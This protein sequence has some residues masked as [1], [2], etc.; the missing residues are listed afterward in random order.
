MPVTLAPSLFLLLIIAAACRDNKPHS[1][2][3]VPS[4]VHSSPQSTASRT[5]SAS[6]PFAQL[7]VAPPPYVRIWQRP[8]RINVPEWLLAHQISARFP[9][10]ECWET[11]AGVPVL[12]GLFCVRYTVGK[13]LYSE[14]T[15]VRAYRS[16]GGRLELVW[17]G[18][19]ALANNSLELMPSISADGKTLE[20]ADAEPDRCFRVIMQACEKG[21]DEKEEHAFI[22]RI[23]EACDKVGRYEWSGKRYIRMQK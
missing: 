1:V 17:E 21:L 15:Q 23:V 18:T 16:E 7:A 22:K 11:P 8:P 6:D 12:P 14:R 3:P 5:P 10:T 19:V 4:S 20:L 9:E 2:R 13:F